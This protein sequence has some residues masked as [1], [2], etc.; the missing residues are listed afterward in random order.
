MTYNDWAAGLRLG[1]H[2]GAVAGH[3]AEA[4]RQVGGEVT[5]ASRHDTVVAQTRGTALEEGSSPLL[6]ACGSWRGQA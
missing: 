3:Q 1:M 2:L 4:R 5:A 6:S